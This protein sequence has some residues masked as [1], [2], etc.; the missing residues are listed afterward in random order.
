MKLLEYED[1]TSI[2]KI[3]EEVTT[4]IQ[5]VFRYAKLCASSATEGIKTEPEFESE[6]DL[7]LIEWIKQFNI[8]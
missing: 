3:W 1:K 5:H 4:T 8:P 2:S 6:N 7:P